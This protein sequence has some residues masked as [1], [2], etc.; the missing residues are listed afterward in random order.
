MPPFQARD[1]PEEI[2]AYA[3]AQQGQRRA[4][5][6]CP[7][8]H[9]HSLHVDLTGSDKGPVVMAWLKIRSL[10]GFLL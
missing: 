3:V 7:Y 4:W 1:D 5:I 6:G 10:S 9:V 2:L 8:M